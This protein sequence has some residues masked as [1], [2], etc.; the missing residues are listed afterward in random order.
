MRRVMEPG[1]LHPEDP[2][3]KDDQVKSGHRVLVVDG[4][5]E[6]EEVLKAVLEP[7][8]LEVNRIRRHF[9]QGSLD[10]NPPHL[11]ILH[12]DRQANPADSEES[13]PEVPRVVIGSVRQAQTPRTPNGSRAEYLA[14]PF[15][16][17]DL[18]RAVEDLLAD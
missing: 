5:A 10:S 12:E 6:T 4:L 15:Q 11:V 2:P 7:Q 8:G 18:I 1:G 14:Q 13:W 16:Y 9:A 17:G 3:G